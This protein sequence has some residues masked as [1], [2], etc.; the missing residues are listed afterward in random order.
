MRTVAMAALLL[1]L[2]TSSGAITWEFEE[3][4][5]GW[6]IRLGG[7][8]GSF[9]PPLDAVVEE[10]VLRI[11][12]TEQFLEQVDFRD[13][14]YLYDR[15][16]V[17]I[18]PQLN[19]DSGLFDRVEVRLRFVHPDPVAT[20]VFLSWINDIDASEFGV[21]HV[22]LPGILVPAVFTSE[23][24]EV[25]FHP[26]DEEEQWDSDATWG[27]ILEEIRLSIDLF[28]S[29]E[30][31]REPVDLGELPEW[32]E[33]DRI[34]LT[35]VEERLQGELPPPEVSATHSPG[36]LFGPA[37]FVP[38]GQEGLGRVTTTGFPGTGIADLDGDGDLD[39]LVPWGLSSPD[40]GGFVAAMNDGT[41][42]LSEIQ[43]PV[44]SRAVDFHPIYYLGGLAD[45]NGDGLVDL[46]YRHVGLGVWLTDAEAPGRYVDQAI[47]G[48]GPDDQDGDGVHDGLP[49]YL[50]DFDGDGDFDLLVSV[51]RWTTGDSFLRLL[52]NDGE[53]G[54][55]PGDFWEFPQYWARRVRDFD[56]DGKLDLRWFPIDSLYNPRARI[57]MLLS[58]NILESGTEQTFEMVV[59]DASG[60]D[61]PAP[62]AY[63]DFS[64]DGS[65]DLVLPGKTVEEWGRDRHSMLIAVNDG[66]DRYF[67]LKPWQGEEV[68]YDH[69]SDYPTSIDL[70]GDGLLD[71]V[72][73]NRHRRTGRNVIVYLGQK[74]G[75]PIEEGRYGLAGFG[76]AVWP[77]D[78]DAD[79][80]LDLV[81]IDGQY[82]GGGLHVLY[83]RLDPPTAVEVS[84]AAVP[85]AHSLGQAY[86]NPFNPDVAIPLTLAE[87]QRQ[88]TVRVY[89]SLGQEVRHLEQGPLAAGHHSLAWDGRDRGG[90][91]VA[92]G[93]YLLRVSAG[94]WEGARKVV[95]TR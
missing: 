22:E 42:V 21:S 12:V 57:V 76:N 27:G 63:G 65:F 36:L 89:N 43:R 74:D 39:V 48:M 49:Q 50:D 70:N 68:V 72:V 6:Q 30:E 92:S 20:G 45:A 4:T 64:G 93:S 17:L 23:W 59:E 11:P 18:S 54:Y 90:Q 19:L 94:G 33:I 78:L 69:I 58:Y 32:V 61:Y 10:G 8:S 44:P 38:M 87:A 14:G 83:N 86:P 91:P 46:F 85:D 81:V 52:L 31:R 29:S 13:E 80:D 5:Q 2:T 3:D 62:F 35:G 24:Q 67:E 77:G 71:V 95:K 9:F 75:F 56:G 73:A 84:S 34:V 16:P 37:Q 40:R 47:P 7:S 55:S 51:D 28:E 1:A 88:V 25:V 79:A 82:R 41:G 15:Y 60:L 66:T 26:L 53:G